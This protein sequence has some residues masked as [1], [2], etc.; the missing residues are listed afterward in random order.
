MPSAHTSYTKLDSNMT[1]ST[2]SDTSEAEMPLTSYFSSLFVVAACLSMLLLALIGQGGLAACSLSTYSEGE[3]D[4]SLPVHCL[5]IVL[6]LPFFTLSIF[7][8][9]CE[10]LSTVYFFLYFLSFSPSFPL[11]PLSLFRFHP[12]THSLS[13][14]LSRSIL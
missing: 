12:V 1:C 14:T 5:F 8:L 3:L 7:C 4:N 10:A 9:S 13:L 11:S 6:F 2:A